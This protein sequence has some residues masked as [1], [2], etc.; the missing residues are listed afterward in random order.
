MSD[1][2]QNAIQQDAL[3]QSEIDSGAANANNDNG[4]DEAVSPR[5]SE[6]ERIAE[7]RRRAMEAEGVDFGAE[8]E[9]GEGDS[10]QADPATQGEP[11]QLAAQLAQDERTPAY[12]DPA[13]RVKVKVDG[14]ELELPLAEVVKSYQ[15]DAA[16]SRRLT[17][18][19]RLLEFAEQQT[20]KIQPQSAKPDNNSPA[21]E[22]QPAPEKDQ[23]RAKIK[24]AASKLYEGD[25]EGFAEEIE[26]LLDGGAPR[27]TQQPS[28]DP[29]QIAA[30]VKQQLAV[31]SAYSEVEKDYPAVFA[32]DERGVVLGR[33]AVQR[34]AT[35]EAQGLPKSQALRESVE[36]VAALFGIQRAGRPTPEPQRTARDDKLERKARL[37]IPGRASVVAGA[38]SSPA[39]ANDVSAT[40]R[41]MAKAR[42]GQSLIVR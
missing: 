10:R 29:V 21:G 26:Q 30:H 9:G 39:E 38:E 7:G 33:E 35:K 18:A 13:L 27:A 20:H 4:A 15:K 5:M 11:D 6:M 3:E 12:A 8:G 2:A 32:T 22:D 31:E 36:E 16:A 41:E 37:D 17:E 19:T 24:S 1:T 40:I 42:L 23:R 25:E 34:M 14:E 28:I